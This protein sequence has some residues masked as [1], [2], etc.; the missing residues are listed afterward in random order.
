[1]GK[2]TLLGVMAGVLSPQHGSVM[3]DGLRRRGSE[4]EELEIRKLPVY[5]P[6]QPWLPANLICPRVPSGPS[7]GF[8]MSKRRG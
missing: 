1:M 6:D 4:E 5:L 8:M 7:A 3:I 2:S